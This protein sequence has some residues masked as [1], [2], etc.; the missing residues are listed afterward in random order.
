MLKQLIRFLRPS[1][2]SFSWRNARDGLIDKVKGAPSRPVQAASYVAAHAAG[3]DPAEVLQLL[4]KF[5]EEERWLMSVGPTKGPLMAELAGTLP[6]NPKVLELGAYCGYSS[7]LIAQ[8]MGAGCHVTSIEISEDS[9]KSARANVEV[10]GLSQQID[11]LH[12]ASNEV[13][14][15]LEGSFDLVFLDHWKDLYKRDLQLIEEY[16]L[17]HTGSIVVADNVGELFNPTSYLDYVRN[18]GRYSS[19]NRRATV[20][21]TQLA[22]ALE[23]SVYHP[24]QSPKSQ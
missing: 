18:C 22:D 21:Y 19:E 9:V 7:I 24:E 14:P 23:I 20:E 11:F 15:S 10:A 17:I 12:G 6:N 13:I 4:D 8:A 3:G 2:L 1:A 16:Q 5:A